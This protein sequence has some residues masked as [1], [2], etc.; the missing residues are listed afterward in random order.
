M[1]GT[2]VVDVNRCMGCKSC[3]LQCAVEHSKSKEL[4]RAISEHP[5]PAARVKVESMAQLT[6]PLQCRQCEDAPC[7][8]ICP[9]KAIERLDKDQP[10]LIHNERCIGC[11]MCIVVCPFGVIGTDTEGKAIIKCDLCFERTTR[12]ELPACVMACPTKALQ[13]KTLEEVAAEKRREFLVKFT[14]E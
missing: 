2:I 6:I 7:A 8:K 9:S 4:F 1:K 12:G 5:R 13:F 3:V 14:R 11:K 10:V